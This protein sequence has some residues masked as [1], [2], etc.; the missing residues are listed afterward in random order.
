MRKKSERQKEYETDIFN[1]WQVKRDRGKRHFIV[2]FGIFTW[3]V[4]T[5]AVYWVLILIFGKITGDMNLVN[6]GQMLF[7]LLFFAAF[8]AIYGALLWKRNEK[9][10]KKKFPYGRKK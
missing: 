10:F 5:F 4:S 6:W 3:G 2:R 8:G 7:T 9:I 1:N